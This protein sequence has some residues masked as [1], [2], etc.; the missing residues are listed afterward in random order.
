M[1]AIVVAV[2]DVGSRAKLGWCRIT[3][4]GDQALAT[5]M[6]VGEGRLLEDLV[7][8]ITE[9]LLADRAVALGFE[10]PLFVPLPVEAAHLGKARVGEGNRPWSA[11]AGAA[12]MAYATQQ[13]TWVLRELAQRIGERRLRVGLDPIAWGAGRLDLLLWEAFVS[14]AAKDRASL[15]PHIDDARA[16]AREFLRRLEA[17]VV[18]SDVADLTV[19]SLVGAAV[20]RAGLSTDIG[21]LAEPPIVIRAP[22]LR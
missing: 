21:P 20:L 13:V 1:K 17:G 22:D 8:T 2:V 11:G 15:D 12:V 10:A 14:G 19:F 18:P 4:F 16:A 9:D 5:D 7:E 3:K 6:G